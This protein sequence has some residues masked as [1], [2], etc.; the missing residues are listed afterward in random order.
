MRLEELVSAFKE[1]QYKWASSETT[2]LKST[3]VFW[4]QGVHGASKG[5]PSCAKVVITVAP[6]IGYSA[7]TGSGTQ[8]VMLAE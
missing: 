4:T 3:K 5:C 2:T 6:G 8:V 7:A 1:S